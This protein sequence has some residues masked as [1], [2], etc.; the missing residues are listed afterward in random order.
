M[1]F[2]IAHAYFVYTLRSR[3]LLK[4]EGNSGNGAKPESWPGEGANEVRRMIDLLS[5]FILFLRE[6]GGFKV[7]GC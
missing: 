6:C 3:S 1:D 5:G 7:D 4:A 2:G